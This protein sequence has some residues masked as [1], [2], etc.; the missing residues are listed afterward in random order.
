MARLALRYPGYGW[1]H[2]AGYATRD[3]VAGLRELGLTPFHRRTYQR[4]RGILAGDQ[5]TLDLES[6]VG[7]EAPPGALVAIAIEVEESLPVVLE[8]VG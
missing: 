2:N 4:V 8:E 6:D 3:H 7:D 5:L 1:E